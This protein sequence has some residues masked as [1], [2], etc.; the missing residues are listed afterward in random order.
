MTFRKEGD[1]R[2]HMKLY[3]S[4]LL[5]SLLTFACSANNDENIEENHN[6]VNNQHNSENTE[7][8][9][10]EAKADTPD[11]SDNLVVESEA[12]SISE[13]DFYEELKAAHG[14]NVLRQ[15]IEEMIIEAEA[16]KLGIDDETVQNE[17]EIMMDQY[18]ADNET[19]FFELFTR[20]DADD[21]D[22][23]EQLIKRQLVMEEYTDNMERITEDT[24]EAEYERGMKVEA[25]HILV[26]DEEE[27]DDLYQRL[28]EDGASFEEL[29]SEYSTDPTSSEEGGNV[30]SFRRGT[31]NPAFEQTAFQ[32]D[33]GEISE[34]VQGPAGYHIIEVL[35]RIP[36][37]EPFEEVQ[38]QLR[39]SLEDRRLY[40]MTE[41][42][43]K[44]YDDYD[45]NINDNDL[46]HL[47]Q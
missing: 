1:E 12:G 47:F 44:L 2:L 32:L 8:Q 17:L 20:Q 25:R 42:Q 16:E 30:G 22:D 24:L 6:D 28:T 38:E 37:D 14:E 36:F 23:L 27:A 43:G 10:D 19:E 9:N 39:T 46:D 35:D 18:G 3:I 7:N 5:L 11:D 4:V 29:A 41:E 21:E 26:S 33:T 31:M 13:S 40:M 34:P 45:I 15:L